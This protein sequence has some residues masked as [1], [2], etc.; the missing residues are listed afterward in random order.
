MTAH[1]PGRSLKMGMVMCAIIFAVIA[2]V[3]RAVS[4]TEYAVT[5]VAIAKLVFFICL[6]IVPVL[7]TFAIIVGKR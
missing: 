2:V 4:V 5:A 1:P 3:A 6:V 7:L